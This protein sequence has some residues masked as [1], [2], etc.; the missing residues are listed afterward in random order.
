MFFE[1][2]WRAREMQM[3]NKNF[4]RHC[5]EMLCNTCISLLFC[6]SSVTAPGSGPST[7][8]KN[9]LKCFIETLNKLPL[10]PLCFLP[11]LY[12][13]L[14]VFSIFRM[15]AITSPRTVE[16]L[17]S[18]GKTKV[19]NGNHSPQPQGSSQEIKQRETIR[20][21]MVSQGFRIFPLSVAVDIHS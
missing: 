13:S 5:V 19:S 10:F 9:D 16:S 15:H 7:G 8:H 6:G 12:M 18:I 2:I 4:V 20:K 17:K 14:Y 21:P 1:A 11:F 3:L